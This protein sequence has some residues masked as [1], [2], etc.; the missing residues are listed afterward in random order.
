MPLDKSAIR[1]A[2]LA[3]RAATSAPEASAFAARLA[4][5][6]LAL[7]RECGA[8]TISAYWPIGDEVSTLPLLD[9]LDEAGFSV[10]LP[11]T[12]RIGEALIFRQWRR[13]DV[14]ERG[15]M[16]IPTP[17][18]DAALLVPDML[19]VPLAA[20]DRGGHR[21]GYGA[22][23]YDRSLAALRE[24]G[25]VTAVGIAY[26]AQEVP[27]VPHEAHDQSLDRIVTERETII[28]AAA[29]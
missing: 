4:N 14:M 1:A 29:R 3:A 19:F 23:F 27:A 8:R 16:G 22:G 6:G 13:G 25:R 18:A 11:V 15:R 24:H 26:A 21:I 12:G 10:A 17:S 9:A 2:A 28:C 5:I 7:A 20:F